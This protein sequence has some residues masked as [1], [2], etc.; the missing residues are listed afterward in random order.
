[1]KEQINHM[2]RLTNVSFIGALLLGIPT[3]DAVA[4]G[5][6]FPIEV[7]GAIVSFDRVNQT[8]TIR[9]DE[10]AQ[11]LT[12][13][14]G[15]D[16]KFKQ[17]GATAN[18]RIIR[19]GARAKVS[20]FA[21]IFSGNIAV[22]IDANP[23]PEVA[24]GIIENVDISNRRLVLS[25]LNS[26]HLALRWARNASFI[27]AGKPASAAALRVRSIAKVAYYAPAFA[28]KYAVRIDLK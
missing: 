15:R 24:T 8:F 20:Y 26:R 2:F 12:I 22:E 18:E 25:E 6:S 27:R 19:G 11:V 23:T 16:C 5:R 9:I 10:P 17:N 3:S 21:T 7:T 28:S 4:R 1:V 14:V 13:G